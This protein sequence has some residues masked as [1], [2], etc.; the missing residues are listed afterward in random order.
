MRRRPPR[1]TLFPYTTLFRSNEQ[2][3][4][5][6]D[7]ST[8]ILINSLLTDK[9][10]FIHIES[11]F[12]EWSISWSV[13]SI[14]FVAIQWETEISGRYSVLVSST[15]TYSHTPEREGSFYQSA[16]FV[17]GIL[18]REIHLPTPAV[19]ITCAAKDTSLSFVIEF[20][21]GKEAHVLVR[22]VSV[23][24]NLVTI[25]LREYS[26]GVSTLNIYLDELI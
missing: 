3:H 17:S 10:V 4:S 25:K 1:S 23:S 11:C 2:N 21:E 7:T 12:E 13:I 19:G 24:E 5:F 20:I 15:Q 9:I 16:E 22:L 18:F 26:I 6:V 14:I 8:D